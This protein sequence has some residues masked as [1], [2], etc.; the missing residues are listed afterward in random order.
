MSNEKE[1][2]KRGGKRVRIKGEK[3][4]SKEVNKGGQVGGL[5]GEWGVRRKKDWKRGTGRKG[6]IVAGRPL[7]LKKS[8]ERQGSSPEELGKELKKE[9]GSTN[10]KSHGR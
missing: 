8:E 9:R 6:E 2:A 1:K 4:K 5:W 7:L 3:R 10:R